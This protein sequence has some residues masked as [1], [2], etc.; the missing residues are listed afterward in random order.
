M[1]NIFIIISFML[2][3]AGLMAQTKSGSEKANSSVLIYP[4]QAENIINIDIK[5]TKE[6]IV[7]HLY[8]KI[9]KEVTNKVTFL[10]NS[11]FKKQL[12]ITN[13]TPGVYFIWYHSNDAYRVNRLIKS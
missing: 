5:D 6:K 9:G 11:V 3:N 2:V 4:D 8:N 12:D 13:L 7:F 1:K 10:I